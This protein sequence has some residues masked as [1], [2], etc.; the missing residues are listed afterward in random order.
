[1]VDQVFGDHVNRAS[2]FAPCLG[3]RAFARDND[4]ALLLE[5]RRP[6]DKIGDIAFILQRST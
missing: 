2:P 6:N 1:M 4:A 3:T 5:Q